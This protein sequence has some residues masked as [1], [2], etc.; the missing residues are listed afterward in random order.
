MVYDVSLLS[1]LYLLSLKILIF[2][3]LKKIDL[4]LKIKFNKNFF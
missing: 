4:I 3:S 2:V 1:E